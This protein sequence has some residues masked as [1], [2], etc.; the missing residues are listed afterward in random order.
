MYTN[1]NLA[2][3]DFEWYLK[4]SSKVKFFILAVLET[5]SEILVFLPPPLFR[6]NLFFL[7]I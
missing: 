6:G 2:H 3:V 7:G 5:L 4:T 1:L